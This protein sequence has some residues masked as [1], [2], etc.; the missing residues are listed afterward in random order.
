MGGAD[1][2]IKSISCKPYED[3]YMDIDLETGEPIP[4]GVAYFCPSC[5]SMIDEGKLRCDC[6]QAILWT[7]EET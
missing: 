6:G 5:C 2:I 7:K 4:V 1:K 3:Y